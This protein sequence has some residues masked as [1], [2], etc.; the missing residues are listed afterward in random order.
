[1]Y[2]CNVWNFPRPLLKARF[3]F[4][5]MER[6]EFYG[7]TLS[8]HWRM[9]P[10]EKALLEKVRTPMDLYQAYGRPKNAKLVGEK[11]PTY[12]AR[13]EQ[14]YRQFPNASFIIL[15]RDPLEVY[16]SV[17]RAGRISRFFAKPGMLSR[18][19][20]LQ[21]QTI[22]QAARIEKNGARVFR[23]T[24]ADIVDRTETVSRDLCQFLSVP[25][26]SKMWNPAS[27]DPEEAIRYGP[28]CGEIAR[29]YYPDEDVSAST[30]AK[31]ERYRTFWEREQADRLKP[32]LGEKFLTPG[33]AEYFCHNALGKV[34]TSYDSLVRAAFEFLPLPWLRNYRQFKKWIFAPASVRPDTQTASSAPPGNT[35]THAT[36]VAGK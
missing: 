33:K 32:V 29:R 19:I 24:Y 3:Q 36:E 4:N 11:S 13:L 1:M 31:L 17:L 23:V 8:R 25:F 27:R 10:A 26:N 14:L 21:D 20:Y 15:W 7:Q 22:R 30:L 34:L 6:L 35:A 9:T 5:W 12:C 18:M 16:R 28:R 2:E